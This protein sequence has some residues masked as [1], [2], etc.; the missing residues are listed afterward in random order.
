MLWFSAPPMHV[1]R[2]PA[3]R[4]SLKYLAYLAGKRREAGGQGTKVD[5]DVDMEHDDEDEDEEAD[6]QKVRNGGESKEK[7]QRVW[8]APTVSE[9]MVSA[10]KE[11]V[12]GEPGSR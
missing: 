7:R 1:A 10:A 6:E 9:I 5:A 2:P 3:A 8:V 4:H 11:V 12:M